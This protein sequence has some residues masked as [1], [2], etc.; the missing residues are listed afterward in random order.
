MR[1]RLL[2][3]ALLLLPAGC[4]LPPGGGAPVRVYG[5]VP[6]IAPASPRREL[7]LVVRRVTIPPYLDRQQM[8][9]RTAGPRLAL[10][11]THNWLEPLPSA[12][13]RVFAADLAALLGTELVFLPEQDPP[14]RADLELT[15]DVFA[16]E[17]VAD[18]RVVLDARVRAR[19]GDEERVHRARI[20][21][22]L[23]RAGDH[24]AIAEAMSE[25]LAELARR[26]AALL[27]DSGSPGHRPAA[28]EAAAAGDH[29]PSSSSNG[30]SSSR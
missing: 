12:I 10:A 7:V 13:A 15:L 30:S 20:T 17:A 19:K 29:P 2:L 4:V 11:E 16:F 24:A 18:R 22:P 27:E 28:T 26:T 8:V 9:T 6:R 25:A 5:L 3:L 14:A 23:A 21:V 1:R